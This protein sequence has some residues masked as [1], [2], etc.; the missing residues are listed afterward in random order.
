VNAISWATNGV[1]VFDIERGPSPSRKPE[2]ITV[3]PAIA[4]RS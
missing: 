1:A 4:L 2:E 3:I